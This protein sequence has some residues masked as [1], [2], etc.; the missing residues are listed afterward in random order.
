MGLRV[1]PGAEIKDLC[2]EIFYRL[3]EIKEIVEEEMGIQMTITSGNDSHHEP[4]SGRPSLHYVN[5]A[6][7]VRSRL[8]GPSYKQIPQKQKLACGARIRKLH[9][10]L[11][12][13]VEY[14]HIHI[15]W[16]TE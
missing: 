10:H 4:R 16:D 12:V 15:E 6:I 3:P 5:Q 13:E 8:E 11:Q 1:K 14:N 2:M 7:D 9:T